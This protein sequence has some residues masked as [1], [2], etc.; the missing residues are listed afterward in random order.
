M[1]ILFGPHFL[2]APERA[3]ERDEWR[4]RLAANNKTGATRATDGVIGRAGVENELEKI[5]VP[6]LI[7]VGEDDKATPVE[8]ARQLHEKIT[9]SRLV[10]VPGA[11]HSVP[12]EQPRAVNEAL[13]AFL[14]D[15]PS[16]TG[17]G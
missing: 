11:A 7:L 5:K 14:A 13:A 15:V 4:T 16:P 9:G 12:I 17:S 1:P 2:T 3:S 10:I 6:T 8:L